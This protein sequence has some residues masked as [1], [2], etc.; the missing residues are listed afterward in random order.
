MDELYPAGM[1]VIWDILEPDPV[2]VRRLVN[3]LAI[4]PLVATLL[5][6]RKITSPE[7]ARA[8]LKP[9]LKGIKPPGAIKDIEQAAERI[10]KAVETNEKILVFG[11]YDVDGV[12]ATALLLEFLRSI[13]AQVSHYIPHRKKEGYGLRSE[14]VHG[15][16]HSHGYR[17]V[18]TVDCGISSH[19]AVM[20]AARKGI[21]VIITDHHLPSEQ[22]PEAVAVINP[23]R[24]DC[25][26]GLDHL[27]GVGMAFY[28]LIELRRQLRRRSFWQGRSEPNLKQL[29]HLV[30]LGTIA[31]MVP[32]VE[33]NR[34]FVHA[35]LQQMQNRPGL[36]ALM[37][38]SRVDRQ[39]V[40]SDDVAFRLAPRINAAGRLA[41]ANLALRLLVTGSR[42]RADRIARLLDRL[43]TRR[44][45]MER[46]IADQIRQKIESEPDLLPRRA[47]IMAGENWHEG[48]L[49]IV[50]AR[51]VREYA[52]P[53]ILLAR[54]GTLARGSAR[55]IPGIDMFQLLT[56]C[57]KHLDHF[58]GHAMAAGLTLPWVNMAA[59]EREMH[60]RLAALTR[61]EDYQQRLTLDTEISLDQITP[62]LLDQLEQL[63]PFG[64]ASPEP[65][66]MLRHVKVSSQRIV[67]GHHRQ[68]VLQSDNKPGSNG[69]QAIQFNVP[70]DQTPVSRFERLAV[71]LRWNR[72]KGAKRPQL[73]VTAADVENK[74][75]GE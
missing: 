44:Q 37:G 8:F 51:L 25:P 72:W 55:S 24:S 16:I 68:M 50:A 38:I 40:E 18:I 53:V 47:L 43:N 58:G 19:D 23:K 48:V 36:R 21:D 66:F 20:Q 57:E 64:Q 49:G 17:L 31:D 26:A 71:H 7:A 29:C 39:R 52:R 41:H 5:V 63:Q 2:A 69:H 6:N 22:L 59:F 54:K 73:V 13:G 65:L 42:Q 70:P 30:A 28:L 34:A 46:A 67:G 56:S 12:T 35:G 15:R 62:E 75:V 74:G 4:D 9:S 45:M 32:L 1:N 33:E 3:E 60:D 11:D 14:H 61:Q 27:A 10:V